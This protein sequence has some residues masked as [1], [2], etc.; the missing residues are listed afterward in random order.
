[1][2][3]RKIAL[4]LLVLCLVGV[5]VTGCNADA[6]KSTTVCLGTAVVAG[7]VTY[8]TAGLTASDFALSIAPPCIEMAY[9]LFASSVVSGVFHPSSPGNR[10]ARQTDV[11]LSE[12]YTYQKVASAQVYSIPLDNCTPSFP[13]VN[14]HYQ[15]AFNFFL[16]FVMAVV[17]RE[18]TTAVYTSRP[19]GKAA[20]AVVADAVYAKYST[21]LAKAVPVLHQSVDIVVAPHTKTTLVLLMT[22]PYRYGVARFTQSG[23]DYYLPWFFAL[24]SQQQGRWQSRVQRC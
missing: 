8:V 17:G 7:V 1:M 18:N 19:A 11:T 13:T 6:P 2:H 10:T 21:L 22:L 15:F 24:S 20:T 23:T 5:C 4:V 12:T 3:M 9:D 16:T 14:L